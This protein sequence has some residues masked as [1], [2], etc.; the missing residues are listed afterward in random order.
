MCDPIT[1]SSGG[2]VRYSRSWRQHWLCISW[3]CKAFDTVPYKR[4]LKK[5]QA[6][7]IHGQILRWIEAFLDNRQQQ[8]C[9][10]SSHSEWMDV[11]SGIPQGSVL[12]PTLF[13]IYINDIP[14]TVENVVK[15]FA[16]DTKIY[17]VINSDCDS[18]SLQ[19]DLDN[20]VDW[21]LRFNTSKVYV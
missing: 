21:Q 12:G 4:L 6:Y 5:L 17:R 16:D 1:G 15:L 14:S 7:G 19:D 3:L 18:L 8:V 13:P 2:M 11:R 20:L 9:V 10:G